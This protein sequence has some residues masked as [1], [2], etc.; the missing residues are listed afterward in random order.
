MIIKRKKISIKGKRYNISVLTYPNNR[1]RLKYENKS[2]SHDITIDL[3]DSYIESNKVFL[4]PAIQHNGVLKAL[5]KNKVVKEIVG[6]FNYNYIDIPIAVLNMS[7]I[8]KYDN[9][10]VDEHL[11]KVCRGTNEN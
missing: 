2:D 7:Y 3:P 8:R 5:R 6:W 10:G 11:K 1:I 4:D 9:D